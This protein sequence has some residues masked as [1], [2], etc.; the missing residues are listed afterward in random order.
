MELTVLRCPECGREEL[1]R[2]KSY[3]TLSTGIR[4]LWL[5]LKCGKC[6]SE[7]KNRL[8]EGLRKSIRVIARVFKDRTHGGMGLNAT[9]E[10]NGLSKNTVLAWEQRLSGLQSTLLLYALTPEFLRQLIAGDEVSTQVRR[11]V[12]QAESDGWTVILMD[13]ASRF[14]WAMEC[15]KKQRQLFQTAIQTLCQ[16]IKQTRDLTLVTDGE[17]RYGNMLFEICQEL[18]RTGKRGRPRLT[19]RQGVKVRLKNK[20]SQAHKR[21]RKRPKY[22][23]PQPEHPET[24]QN[25]AQAEIHAN[26][27]E[28]QNSALRR[29]NSAYR[30]R[31]NTYAKRVDTLQ[32]TLDVH[33]IMH[34][35]VKVH[36]TTGAVPAVKL[37]ILKE[38]F[39]WEKLFK[40]Q[41][42]ENVISL[43]E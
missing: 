13:R 27:L 35:F 16:V 20:G 23:A 6:F 30:R 36:F 8:L 37:G 5:C 10:N 9:A 21:G 3:L 14:I 17:R 1:K 42:L 40:I 31:T 29:R 25:L 34:N 19:L 24:H 41:R 26:H 15:G 12:P 33:W 39:S 7:T 28:G 11:N 18:I 4:W 2:Q 22:E 38:G 32:R 43:I